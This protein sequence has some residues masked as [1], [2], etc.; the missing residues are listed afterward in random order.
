MGRAE[1][2]SAKKSLGRKGMYFG[3][4][5]ISCRHPD[6][7][8][9][10]S[11]SKPIAPLRSRLCW[12]R[13]SEPRRG[14]LWVG[15]V[16]LVRNFRY[17]PGL[18]RLQELARLVAIEQWIVGFDAKEKT[19]VAGQRES[20]HVESRVIEHRQT[21]QAQQAEN[22]GE[23]RKQNGHLERDDDVGGPTVQRPS[24]DIDRV[25]A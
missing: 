16:F 19:V 7:K 14:T 24:A 1:R 15:S 25:V 5:C 21:A 23:R 2:P 9:T 3:W 11:R 20:R 13:G 18:Q 4:S 6:S 17:L 22:G 10:D 8:T 12:V